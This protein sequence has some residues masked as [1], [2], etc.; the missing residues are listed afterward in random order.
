LFAM[1]VSHKSIYDD[2]LASKEAGAIA[3]IYRIS[4]DLPD[5]HALHLR[6]ALGNYLTSVTEKEYRTMQEGKPSEDTRAALDALYAELLRLKTDTPR[7]AMVL[8]EM[9]RQLDLVTQ[10]RRARLVASTGVVPGVLWVTLIIGA[11]GTLGFTLFFGTP[12]V[13]A[14]AM[15]TGILSILLFFGLLIVVLFYHR[16]AGAVRGTTAAFDAIA[17]DFIKR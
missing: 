9:L 14:Q 12:N 8:G 16:F 11:I 2:T 4:A 7:Q 3:T 6:A 10:M 15:M 13:R 17:N 5:V 1:V